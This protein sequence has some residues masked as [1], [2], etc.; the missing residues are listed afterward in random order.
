MINGIQICDECEK[1]YKHLRHYYPLKLEDEIHNSFNWDSDL[2]QDIQYQFL[3]ID[4][5]CYVLIQIHWLIMIL[6]EDILQP[7]Y[8]DV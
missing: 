3:Y 8:L 4:N 7:S 5:D 2:S 6:E 1:A